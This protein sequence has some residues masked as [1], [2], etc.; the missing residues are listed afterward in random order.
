MEHVVLVG[1]MG[2]GKTTAGSELA[3][4][5]GRPFLDSDIQ[6]ERRDGVTAA[7][8]ATRDGVER[9]HTIEL[10]IFLDMVEAD[11]PSV[12]S[13]AASVIDTEQGR[14]ILDQSLVIWMDA[15]EDVLA[16]RR[17]SDGHRRHVDEDE[18]TDLERPRRSHW[19]RLARTRIDTARPVAEVVDELASEVRRVEAGWK[20]A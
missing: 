12:I 5:L 15:P 9:L 19:E 3:S 18:A 13:P 20:S 17:G 10:E 6:L 14:K 16:E 7:E 8:I 1:P 2:V 4:R 11:D